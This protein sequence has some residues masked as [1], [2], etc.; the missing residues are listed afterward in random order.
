M[1][2][3]C[4][5]SD[6]VAP[7]VPEPLA[8]ST[9]PPPAGVKTMVVTGGGGPV[10]PVPPPPPPPPHAATAVARMARN[11]VPSPGRRL[12][13]VMRGPPRA[14]PPACAAGAGHAPAADR[15]GGR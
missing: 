5:S 15:A 3:V 14:P 2:V 8:S 12:G 6:R 1:P 10:G 9:L 13:R 7:W 4:T 11:A